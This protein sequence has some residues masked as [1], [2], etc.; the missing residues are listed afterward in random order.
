[1]GRRGGGE[2][3]PR[4]A[5]RTGCERVRGKDSRAPV[6]GRL[7]G[8]RRLVPSREAPPLL[9]PASQMDTQGNLFNFFNDP[10]DGAQKVVPVGNVADLQR[11][12][13]GEIAGM[14]LDR[15]VNVV[16]FTVRPGGLVRAGR[17]GLG[18]RAGLRRRR[19]AGTRAA[20]AAGRV[21]PSRAPYAVRARRT[22]R[23]RRCRPAP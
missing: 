12:K 7:A 3:R 1:M 18:P 8:R 19:S 14:R 4:A 13:I 2:R 10:D 22:A 15:E 21:A 20:A 9:S 16:A 5:G 23:P 17:R 11:F 6:R